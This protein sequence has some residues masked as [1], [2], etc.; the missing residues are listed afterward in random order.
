MLLGLGADQPARPTRAA[1][2]RCRTPPA[3][4]TTTPPAAGTTRS[5]SNGRG[6]DLRHR[7]QHAG[8]QRRRQHHELQRLQRLRERR[9]RLPGGRDHRRNR[10]RDAQRDTCSAAP[11]SSPASPRRRSGCN[12]WQA[13]THCGASG[14]T[15]GTKA[16]AAPA[17]QCPEN[18]GTDVYVDPSAGSDVVGRRL[19]DRHPVAGRLP[20]RLAHQRPHQGRL[21]R[22]G[23][24]HQRDACRRPSAVRRFPLTIPAGVTLM[25]ADAVFNPADYVIDFGGAPADAAVTLG[26]GAALRRVHGRGQRPGVVADCRAY[27]TGSAVLLTRSSLTATGPSPTASTSSAELRGDASRT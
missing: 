7:Q 11:T 15:C 2:G 4:A 1:R 19:P 24:R 25:T 6:R 27:A 16:S 5:A 8:L 3:A 21:A 23:H 20:L 12:I 26:R 14:L 10:L 17:C 18:T 22:A 13:S 9:L